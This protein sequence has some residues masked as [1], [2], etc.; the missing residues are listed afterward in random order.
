MRK[1]LALILFSF[2][3]LAGAGAQAMEF[4][5]AVGATY[6]KPL[7]N[8][9]WYQE[10]F[11]YSMQRSRPAWFIGVSH[12]IAEHWRIHV[13]YVDLGVYHVDAI[14]TPVDSNYNAATRSCN[15]DCVARSRFISSGSANGIRVPIEYF[16]KLSDDREWNISAG[17]YFTR[18]PWRV[19]VLDW[20]QVAT[21]P[22]ITIHVENAARLRV[23]A[24]IGAG[25]KFDKHWEARVDLYAV[26][27]YK[28]NVP[29]VWQTI[30]AGTLVYH[31]N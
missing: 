20:K 11:P 14:A 15:G 31:F 27:G 21:D 3:F 22:G 16:K 12:Q 1:I 25:Y 19:T 28:D 7:P 30:T 2:L 29:A 17:P 13:D 24:F 18:E 4:E 26:R 5:A 9:T 8:G 23:A 10:G 6:M